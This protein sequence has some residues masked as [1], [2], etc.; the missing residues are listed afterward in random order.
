MPTEVPA[1]NRVSFAEHAQRAAATLVEPDRAGQVAVAAT[2]L[3]PLQ[4]IQTAF[5]QLAGHAEGRRR[6]EFGPYGHD[7]RGYVQA[8]LDGARRHVEELACA[9]AAADSMFEEMT[10]QLQAQETAMAKKKDDD[11]PQLTTGGEPHPL[12]AGGYDPDAD[13]QL[14]GNISDVEALKEGKMTRAQ[15]EA[16]ARADAEAAEGREPAKS[17][18]ADTRPAPPP[19]RAPY[20]PADEDEDH[21]TKRGKGKK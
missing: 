1:V 14:P 17:D 5:D 21:P 19:A 16:V 8:E 10:R 11:A 6:G 13:P 18:E 4:R 3:A 12:Q 2:R 9:H 20:A 15:S 7:F